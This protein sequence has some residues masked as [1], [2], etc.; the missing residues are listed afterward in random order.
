MIYP[1]PD[2]KRKHCSYRY[3]LGGIRLL[4]LQYLLHSFHLWQVFIMAMLYIFVCKFVCLPIWDNL[5]LFRFSICFFCCFFIFEADL[6]LLVSHEKADDKDEKD[7]EKAE[8]NTNNI[9]HWYW[10][11]NMKSK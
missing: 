2:V 6:L 3:F 8:D 11:F 9:A 7:D 10:I 4:F 1:S 5:I